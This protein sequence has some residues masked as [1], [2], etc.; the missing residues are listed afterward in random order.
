MTWP[1]PNTFIFIYLYLAF[2]TKMKI[3]HAGIKVGTMSTN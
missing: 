3:Y 2:T 1:Q